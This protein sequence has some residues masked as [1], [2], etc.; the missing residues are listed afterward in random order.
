M[1][2]GSSS[3]SEPLLRCRRGGDGVSHPQTSV[4]CY[5]RKEGL[6]ILPCMALPGPSDLSL[7]PCPHCAA[8]G[9]ATPPRRHQK[10]EGLGH[11]QMGTAGPICCLLSSE[12]VRCPRMGCSCHCQLAGEILWEHSWRTTGTAEILWGIAGRLWDTA[13]G[14]AGGRAAALP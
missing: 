14:T 6:Q 5:E 7:H 13:D 11:Y 9:P 8:P 4:L 10:T 2:Q 3:S 12:S 1:H